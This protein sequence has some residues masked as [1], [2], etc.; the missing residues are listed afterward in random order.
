MKTAVVISVILGIGL[1]P[2]ALTAQD[3]SI[4]RA[5]LEAITFEIQESANLR[6]NLTRYAGISVRG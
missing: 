1:F 5:D 4:L 6:L 3:V 2:P